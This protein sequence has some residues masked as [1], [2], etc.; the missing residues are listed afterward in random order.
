M[1]E[2]GDKARQR[3]AEGIYE[4]CLAPQ[5]ER[6]NLAFQQL[7]SYLAARL[8][9]APAWPGLQASGLDA[10]VLQQTLLEIW[11]V[12]QRP[13]A[14]L[15]QPAAFLKW[16][17]VILFRQ[18]ALALKQVHPLS[19]E[20]QPA[21]LLENLVETREPD[22]LAALVQEETRE[23][24][25][26][27]IRTLKNPH[28][29]RVLLGTYFAEQEESELAARWQVRVQDIYLWRYRALKA[30]RKQQTARPAGAQACA[31]MLNGR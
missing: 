16:A 3:Y 15:E 11:S 9:Q 31:R 4:G 26:N 21:D 13:G 28:Y 17:R 10:E 5:E 29:Q 24:L 23:E 27:A 12:L 30:L 1:Q 20:R 14:R 8:A 7:T 18:M 2:P 6:R 25:A 19:L 22:P